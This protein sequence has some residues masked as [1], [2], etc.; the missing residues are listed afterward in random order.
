MG[1]GQG[2]GR[3]RGGCQYYCVLLPS[4]AESRLSSVPRDQT[5]DNTID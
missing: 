5:F 1:A 4:L 2:R 3:E